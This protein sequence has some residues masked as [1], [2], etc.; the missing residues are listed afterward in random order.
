MN[1][2]YIV[3]TLIVLVS[4]LMPMPGLGVSALD[5][6]IEAIKSYQAHSSLLYSIP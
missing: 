2:E 1:V 3:V 5:W 6:L 4:V